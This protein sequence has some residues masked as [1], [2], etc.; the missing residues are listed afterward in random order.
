MLIPGCE[1]LVA[2]H[3]TT[4]GYLLHHERRFASGR[5]L[6]LLLLCSCVAAV[7]FTSSLR[8]GIGLRGKHS[9][10]LEGERS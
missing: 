5:S 9:L 6:C 4:K 10:N 3:S 2:I 7:Q 8:N 1:R